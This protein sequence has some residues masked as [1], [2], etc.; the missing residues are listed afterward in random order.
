[1]EKDTCLMSS[2]CSKCNLE[3]ANMINCG[4]RIC[5]KCLYC[6]A[7]PICNCIIASF[8][9]IFG[10]LF[11]VT[12]TKIFCIL[13]EENQAVYFSDISSNQILITTHKKDHKTVYAEISEF[14]EKRVRYACLRKMIVSDINGISLNFCSSII[15]DVEC[16]AL[17]ITD[18]M[19]NIR[20]VKDF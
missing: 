11:K 13:P 14:K 16:R 18:K 8:S 3:K 12:E 7:C 1:M 15:V 19:Y 4:H 17:F 10:V 20:F 2:L 9:E 6:F 5:P